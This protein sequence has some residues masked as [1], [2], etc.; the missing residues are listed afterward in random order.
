MFKIFD[1]C[2]GIKSVFS[3]E[4]VGTKE[5]E[6][7]KLLKL[8]IERKDIINFKWTLEQMDRKPSAK[9]V[10]AIAGDYSWRVGEIGILSLLKMTEEKIPQEVLDRIV[11]ASLSR[12]KYDAFTMKEIASM[13]ASAETC[14]RLFDDL[15]AREN[16]F[17]VDTFLLF[18]KGEKE[19]KDLLVDC[20]KTGN[21][22]FVK[23]AKKVMFNEEVSENDGNE[24]LE[25]ALTS[26]KYLWQ[27]SDMINDLLKREITLEEIDCFVKS[28]MA[29]V[30]FVRDLIDVWTAAEK[31]CSV[32]A[33]DQTMG[34]LAEYTAKKLVSLCEKRDF[35]S[36][37]EIIE[38]TKIFQKFPELKEKDKVS[39]MFAE[40][41]TMLLKGGF[42]EVGQVL[43]MLNLVKVTSLPVETVD[44]IIKL[45]LGLKSYYSKS[46]WAQKDFEWIASLGASKSIV[47]KLALGGRIT[48]E[49]AKRLGVSS[50]IQKKLLSKE[51]RTGCFDASSLNGNLEAGEIYLVRK[52]LEREWL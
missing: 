28:R 17:A 22:A 1:L 30:K 14:K 46:S 41:S 35:D 32:K 47:E 34:D 15:F 29:K 42:I 13:G 7:D 2:K 24:I 8:S 48:F 5:E 45:L 21:I 38:Q 31:G 11:N 44:E 6:L 12:E 51:L 52:N 50:D 23:Y 27:V 20:K 39:K 43:E 18:N 25:S 4:P 36:G 10:I 49:G 37:K 19:K 26:R 40:E 9:E 33:G 16:F 3:K